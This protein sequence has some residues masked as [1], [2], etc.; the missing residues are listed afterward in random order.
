M[1]GTRQAEP[2]AVPYPPPH[3]SE[4]ESCVCACVWLVCTC[5][6]IEKTFGRWGRFNRAE[7]IPL[8]ARPA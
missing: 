4:G 8:K 5:T 6:V 1:A 2:G 7:I 3:F